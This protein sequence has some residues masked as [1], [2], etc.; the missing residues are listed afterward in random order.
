MI[1]GILGD[2]GSGKTLTALKELLSLYKLG[3][4][5]YTNIALTMPHKRITLKMLEKI[6]ER[7]EG[8]GDDDAV[9][10]LDE[11]HIWL[12]SRVSASKRNRIISYFLLQ[13]RKLGR[14]KDYGMI[15]IYTTQYPDLIDKR[16]RK[17]T[18]RAG[19]CMKHEIFWRG[20]NRKLFEV[21][22]HQIINGVECVKSEFFFGEKYYPLYDTREIVKIEKSSYDE[23]DVL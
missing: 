17:P 2:L 10:F 5:I 18:I 14:N 22:W 11:I 16:L 21:E 8:F 4:N 20:R 19:F 1:I 23:D 15:F 13:T 3:Y 9:V 12:D 7:G 6:V